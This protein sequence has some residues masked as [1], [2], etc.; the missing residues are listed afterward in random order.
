MKKDLQILIPESHRDVVEAVPRG[1]PKAA[2]NAALLLGMSLGALVATVAP[3]WVA[4]AVPAVLLI[5]YLIYRWRSNKF[6]DQRMA[7]I[8]ARELDWKTENDA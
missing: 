7:E 8:E 1:F 5:A 2:V 3:A 6:Y 4:A